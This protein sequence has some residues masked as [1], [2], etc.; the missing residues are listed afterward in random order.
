M[1]LCKVALADGNRMVA[2]QPGYIYSCIGAKAP[3]LGSV[4]LIPE[5]KLNLLSCTHLD[6]C[7]VATTFFR[8]KCIL[9]KRDQN[10]R[11][12]GRV[13]QREED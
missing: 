4:S 6:D 11:I 9:R 5:I 8:K 3:S 7:R 2:S 10:N 12:I 1:E 13:S